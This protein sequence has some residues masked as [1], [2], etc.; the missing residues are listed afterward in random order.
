MHESSIMHGFCHVEMAKHCSCLYT[1][2]VLRE[3][4]RHSDLLPSS[5]F[6]DEEQLP[7]NPTSNIIQPPP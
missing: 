1:P 6:Q 4:K 2:F 5:S 7:A 3:I